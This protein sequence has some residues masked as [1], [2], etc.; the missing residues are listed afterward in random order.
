MSRLDRSGCTYGSSRAHP[1]SNTIE[2][3]WLLIVNHTPTP[4]RHHSDRQTIRPL[5][6][7]DPD[8]SGIDTRCSVW[9]VRLEGCEYTLGLRLLLD[10]RV[11]IHLPHAGREEFSYY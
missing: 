11:G 3:F 6:Y 7:S 10:W 1:L 5:S 4:F 8:A 9:L 2:N